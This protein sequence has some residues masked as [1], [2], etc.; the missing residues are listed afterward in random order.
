MVILSGHLR[1]HKDSLKVPIGNLNI[2]DRGDR[3][4]FLQWS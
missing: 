3:R 1:C 2:P 4:F